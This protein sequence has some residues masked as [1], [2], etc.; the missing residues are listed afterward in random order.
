MRGEFALR[1][2]PTD[3]TEN[4]YSNGNIH[5]QEAKRKK[6]EDKELISSEKYKLSFQDDVQLNNEFG[7]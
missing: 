7:S 6:E 2:L 5:I 1:K 3:S 4:F